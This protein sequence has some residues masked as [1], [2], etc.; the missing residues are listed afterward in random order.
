LNWLFLSEWTQKWQGNFSWIRLAEEGR[1]L[2]ETDPPTYTGRQERHIEVC[3]KSLWNKSPV[4]IPNLYLECG[5]P[6]S[7]CEFKAFCSL[8]YAM[9]LAEKSPFG[10]KLSCY[11]LVSFYKQAAIYYVYGEP[12]KSQARKI[13][14]PT[15][16]LSLSHFSFLFILK[17]VY[18]LIKMKSSLQIILK[19][20]TNFT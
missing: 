7:L 8:R 5:G 13:D 9:S 3:W 2:K 10:R 15:L 18:T 17:S 19:S 12:R 20:Y 14:L 11:L 4:D 1:V 6:F 16:S